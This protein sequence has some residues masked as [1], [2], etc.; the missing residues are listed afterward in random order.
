MALFR[1]AALIVSFMAASVAAAQCVS[2]IR[3]VKSDASLLPGP[4]AWSGRV[5]AVAGT[6]AIDETTQR[7]FVTTFDSSG[8]QLS[9]IVLVP[10][11]TGGEIIG[12]VWN[13]SEFALFFENAQHEMLIRRL[14]TDGKLIGG[15][16]RRYRLTL[17]DDDLVEVEWS[18]IWNR[19]LLARIATVDRPGVWLSTLELDGDLEENIRLDDV[20]ADSP[21]DLVQTETGLI[22]VFYKEDKG[23]FLMMRTAEP[24]RALARA[25]RVWRVTESHHAVARGNWFVLVRSTEAN[26]LRDRVQWKWVDALGNDVI[27][28]KQIALIANVPDARPLAFISTPEGFALSYVDHD[29]EAGDLVLRIRR[30]DLNGDTVADTEFGPGS[31]RRTGLEVDDL[32]YDG[33]TY[34]AI[35]GLNRATGTDSMYSIRWCPLRAR[36][37]AQRTARPGEIVAFTAVAEGGVPQYTYHWD[38]GGHVSNTRVFERAFAQQGTY[39]VRLTVRDENF[40]PVVETFTIEIV[41]DTPEEPGTGRRR[42]VRK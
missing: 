32:V 16:I 41:A 30:L 3:E 33:Q 14:G 20:G 24:S 15:A 13:G 42:S 1:V 21:L 10:D 39:E 34:L 37:E 26:S 38:S 23:D 29:Y 19:Y 31:R 40:T 27:A 7:L 36:I 2:D 12:L 17:A 18:A 4:I 11:S 25:Q 35:G 22:A 6:Q 5:L 8:N 28:E 9:P